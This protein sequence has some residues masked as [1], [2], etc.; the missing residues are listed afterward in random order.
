MRIVRAARLWFKGGSSDKLYEVD[1]V[2]NDGLFGDARFLVNFRY[3]RRGSSLREGT[4]TTVPVT[5]EA[6]EKVFDSVVVAKVNEGY[7]RTDQGAAAPSIATSPEAPAPE[8]VEGRGLKLLGRLEAHLRSPWPGPDRDRLLWRIGEVRLRAATPTLLTLAEKSGPEASYSLVFALA[9]AAGAAAA[10]RLKTI[11]RSADSALVRDLAAFALVSPLM[12][13]AR[14]TG[15]LDSSLPRSVIE[16]GEARDAD[17]IV[18]ALADLAA[19]AKGRSLDVGRSLVALARAAQGD[20]ALNAALAAAVARLPARPPYLFGLRKL[21]KYAEMADDAALFGA[22]AHRFETAT[23]MYK[24]S[25]VYRGRVH[26]P[27]LGTRLQLDEVRDRPDTQIGLA[28]ATL[29]YFKRRIWRTLRKRGELGDPTFAELA[30]SYLLALQPAD[31]SAPA[32]W[33]H[34]VYGANGQWNREARSSGPLSKNWTAS[35]LLQRNDRRS[36][37]RYGSLTFQERPS[38]PPGEGRPEAFPDLWNARPDLGLRLAAESPVWPA[39]MLGLRVLKAQPA[40]VSALASAEIGRLLASPHAEVAALAFSEARDRLA[41]GTADD[42]LLAALLGADLVEARRLATERIEHDARLPWSGERLALA[43]ITASHSDLAEPVARWSRE[44]RLAPGLAEPLARAV[45]AWLLAVPAH[46]DAPA[47]AVI[48]AARSRLRLLWPDRTMPAR[49]EDVR[50]LMAHPAPAIMA[51]GIDILGLSGTDPSTIADE[52][53]RALLGSSSEDVQEAALT[54]FGGLGDEDLSTHAP[55]VVAFATSSSSRLRQAARPLVARI[56]ERDPALADRLAHDLIGTLF[57]SAPDEDYPADIIALLREAMPRQLAALDEAT[58]WRMLQA[59]AKGAQLLGADLL[60]GRE[61]AAFSVRQIARLGNHAH[62]A[63]RQWAM[64]AYAAAPERFRAEAADAVLLVESEWPEVY[65]FARQQFETWPPEAWT[66]ETL[67]VVTDSVKPPVLDFARHLLRSRLA[68]ADA[69]A[70]LTRLLEHPAQAM[71][72]LVTEMLTQEAAGSDAAFAKLLPLARIV[73]LQ[74]LKGR[75][76]KDRMAAFL[77]AEALRDRG[78]AERVAPLF[79][80]LTLSGTERDRAHAVLALRDIARAH[81]GIAL[82]I[83]SR[84]A[85]LR[86]TGRA[87]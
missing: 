10:D 77:T 48:R 68:P 14:E 61:P 39:A 56:A 15:A 4:K 9:R 20:A 40:F 23:P 71:H 67:A 1:L 2:E 38:A 74:V 26:V 70:Q 80:D 28:D 7:R 44:R 78:R 18:G 59:R 63:V 82:P 25:R 8:A 30:T 21:Y 49:P 13:D 27:E 66:P 58:V 43:A 64:A 22:S 72:L 34:F 53:W 51:A 50:Q 75:V 73:M 55:L 6:A 47:E 86:P 52:T 17:R 87:A 11:A 29:R 69:E 3:G 36:V 42:D 79:A 83:A 45:V 54:L 35:Q 37:A 76:A 24:T 32:T 5:R 62:L 16:A 65:D 41:T 31:L 12:G 57:L 19:S 81:P 60:L 85:P 46:P 84:P 33:T